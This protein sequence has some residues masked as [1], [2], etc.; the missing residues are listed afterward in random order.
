MAKKDFSKEMMEALKTAKS[1]EDLSKA[2]EAEGFDLQELSLED[3]D[4][5]AGGTY[6]QGGFPEGGNF[7]GMLKAYYDSSGNMH[8][9]FTPNRYTD[10]LG[11]EITA[12]QY[13]EIYF[14]LRAAFPEIECENN[15]H[16]K[17]NRMFD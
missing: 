3:L 7:G 16:Q 14:M 9:Y 10:D 13:E 12:E 4:Q 1:P 17:V 5:V 6:S 11:A 15:I 2:L 8:F